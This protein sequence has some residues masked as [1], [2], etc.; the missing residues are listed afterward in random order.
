M[1]IGGVLDKDGL[2]KKERNYGI[3]LLRIVS[4]FFV[5]VLHVSNFPG[6]LYY[7][8]NN[9]IGYFLV[10]LTYAFAICSVNIYAMISGYV[11]LNSKFKLKRLLALWL[12]VFFFNV[13]SYALIVITNGS[14]NGLLDFAKGMLYALPLTGNAIW[15]FKAYFLLYMLFPVLNVA[16]RNMT[17][18]QF[19][20]LFIVVA[21]FI[22]V[23]SN[24]NVENWYLGR[25]YSTLWL[26]I[27]YF[28][29][30]YFKKFGLTKISV[31]NS[32]LLYCL[33]SVLIILIMTIYNLLPKNYAIIEALRF[34]T[35][36]YTSIFVVLQSVFLFIAFAKIK[37]KNEK[38]KRI[39]LLVSPLTFGIYVMHCT[40]YGISLFNYLRF[41]PN[42]SVW[43]IIPFTIGIAVLIFT[44]CA[45]IEWV[46]QLLFKY[47]G[48]DKLT[49]K[50]G[51]FIQNKITVFA[52]K[53]A[54]GE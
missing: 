47:S 11:L 5:V 19:I 34:E 9:S 17:K 49:E 21:V 31:K 42:Y 52:E 7:Y 46:R 50:T 24:Y 22:G 12:E 37:P 1:V 3:D 10:H 48:I 51:D 6:L 28:V 40:T 4:M 23:L 8:D 18:K 26:L 39:I 33:M 45:F 2:I 43:L 20:L 13:V 27:M 14:W 53:K 15:Y 38:F 32:L 41:I 16:I 30:A 36:E 29:G 35:Y 44:V 25:G 54:D